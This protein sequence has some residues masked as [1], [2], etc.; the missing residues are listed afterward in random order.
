MRFVVVVEPV[1]TVA[2]LDDLAKKLGYAPEEIAFSSDQSGV[3]AYIDF[4]GKVGQKTDLAH[5]YSWWVVAR[6]G[7]YK[8][9][10]ACYGIAYTHKTLYQIKWRLVDPEEWAYLQ[11]RYRH[12]RCAHCG[13]GAIDHT[14]RKLDMKNKA[15]WYWLKL[16]YTYRTICLNT[17]AS[18]KE[19]T[20]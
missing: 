8:A 1:G 5:F 13:G 10:W 4:F 17:N 19:E 6:D 16:H 15:D 18:V 11:D 3:Q 20:S 2:H 7:E 14:R 9:M 12:D